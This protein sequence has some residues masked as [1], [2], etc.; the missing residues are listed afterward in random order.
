MPPAVPGKWSVSMVHVCE[1][2]G[3]PEVHLMEMRHG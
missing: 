1:F 2:S 3:T